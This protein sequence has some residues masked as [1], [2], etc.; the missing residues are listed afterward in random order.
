MINCSHN[1]IYWS[2]KK[3]SNSFDNPF[4]GNDSLIVN[5]YITKS[6][7]NRF[8]WKEMG[9]SPKCNQCRTRIKQNLVNHSQVWPYFALPLKYWDYMHSGNFT[10]I[11]WTSETNHAIN[12]LFWFLSSVIKI[13]YRR[14]FQNWYLQFCLQYLQ[15]LEVRLITDTIRDICNI[16]GPFFWPKFIGYHLWY[17]K[18]TIWTMIIWWYICWK[19][20]L[21]FFLNLCWGTI[22]P[23]SKQQST[24][25][26]TSIFLTIYIVKFGDS[27]NAACAGLSLEF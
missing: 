24:H 12:R 6:W 16:R 8:G 17:P 11:K 9:D 20:S 18:N 21:H 27:E 19:N 13:K 4:H 2:N 15:F 26:W 1:R 7:N 23:D 3:K 5:G 25:P 22:K 10:D 14:K